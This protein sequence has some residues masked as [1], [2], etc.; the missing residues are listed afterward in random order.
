MMASHPPGAPRAPL[1][2][3]LKSHAALV[4]TLAARVLSAHRGEIQRVAVTGSDGA[5]K[6]RLADDLARRIGREGMPVIRATI[7]SFHNPRAVRYRLGRESPEGFYRDSFDLDALRAK[8]LDP[9]SPGGSRAYRLAAFDHRADAPVAAPLLT[10]PAPATLIVD[11]IFLQRPELAAYWDLAIFL[12]VPFDIAFARLAARD[13]G[14]A[15]PAAAA[16]RRY[17]DG[18]LLYFAECRPQQT[19]DILVDYTDLNRPRIVR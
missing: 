7:D 18:Q 8:L 6:T 9:L 13:G 12:D 10:A 19:A 1:P 4:S 5:G 14:S 16:N 11:G 3:P 15:D 17:R 2:R